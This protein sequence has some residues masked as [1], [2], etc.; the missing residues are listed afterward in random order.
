MAKPNQG[1]PRSG[2]QG[3]GRQQGGGTGQ[4]RDRQQNQQG[5]I[6]R[7]RQ[8]GDRDPGRQREDQ[9]RDEQQR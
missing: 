8:Q 4:D 7:N 6:D 1:N 9:R 2:Q 5:G 3:A